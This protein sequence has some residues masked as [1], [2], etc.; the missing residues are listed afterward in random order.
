VVKQF[1]EGGREGE[2]YSTTILPLPLILIDHN[3]E[4]ELKEGTTTPMVESEENDVKLALKHL[5][6]LPTPF[7]FRVLAGWWV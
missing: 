7:F 1:W 6:T 5:L 4:V 2:G 3:V